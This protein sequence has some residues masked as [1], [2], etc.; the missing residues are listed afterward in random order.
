MHIGGS[1]LWF[2]TKHAFLWHYI[3]PFKEVQLQGLISQKTIHP[4][5]MKLTG[6]TQWVIESLGT[7]FP[8]ILKFFKNVIIL[9]F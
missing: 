2:K 5:F 7:N 4:I 8:S 1:E 9:S 6:H 3:D